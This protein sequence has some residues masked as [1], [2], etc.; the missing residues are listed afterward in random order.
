MNGL[1]KNDSGKTD[2]YFQAADVERLKPAGIV[3]ALNRMPSSITC[4]LK[5][6]RDGCTSHY[7]RGAA[8]GGKKEP[9]SISE[10][11]R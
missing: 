8:S 7:R 11:G 5:K 9:V 1:S 4:K 2:G 3:A 6:G 10:D